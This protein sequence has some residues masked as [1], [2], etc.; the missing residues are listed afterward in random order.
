MNEHGQVRFLQEMMEEVHQLK[1]M[2][3]IAGHHHQRSTFQTANLTFKEEH[4]RIPR[5]LNSNSGSIDKTQPTVFPPY[6]HYATFSSF[7]SRQLLVSEHYLTIKHYSSYM[8]IFVYT[9]YSAGVLRYSL[10]RYVWFQL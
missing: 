1:L 7:P 10:I 2:K 9:L 6:L 3:S 8:Y 5:R 4:Q